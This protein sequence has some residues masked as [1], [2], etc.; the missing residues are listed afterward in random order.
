MAATCASTCSAVKVSGGRSAKSAGLRRSSNQA[1]ARAPKLLLASR[2][3]DGAEQFDF[4]RLLGAGKLIGELGIALGGMGDR[5]GAATDAVG[6]D[7]AAASVGENRHDLRAL[8]RGGG[9]SLGTGRSSGGRVVRVHGA[10]RSW[11]RVER[12]AR[13]GN[14]KRYRSRGGRG[15][16]HFSAG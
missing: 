11:G 6:G 1:A 2:I 4:R 10:P 15:L 14:K 7:S 8:E 13:G 16:V 3:A 9:G 5:A 12:V